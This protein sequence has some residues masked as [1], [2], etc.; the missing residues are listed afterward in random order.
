MQ[1]DA[2]KILQG[3][4]LGSDWLWKQGLFDVNSHGGS[5]QSQLLD[6]Y[7]QHGFQAVG[8]GNVMRQATSCNTAP[9]SSRRR[10]P[11]RVFVLP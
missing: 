11:V 6:W 8:H 9:R 2:L 7:A 1:N 4:V 3:I 10:P 5:S